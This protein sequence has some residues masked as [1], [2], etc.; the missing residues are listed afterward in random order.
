M[1]LKKSLDY[2]IFRIALLITFLGVVSCAQTNEIKE[3]TSISNWKTYRN[4]D[5]GFELNYPEEYIILVERLG[6]SG[7][8]YDRGVHV[9]SV[10]IPPQLFPNSNLLEGRVAVSQSQ[11]IK[12][13][14][15]CKK[16]QKDETAKE[17][18]ITEADIQINGIAFKRFET[19]GGNVGKFGLRIYRAFQNEICFE[20]DV[21]LVTAGTSSQV[22]LNDVENDVWDK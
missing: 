14:D 19:S 16:L 9:A 15:D 12:S 20:I 13:S 7:G 17:Q 8:T 22:T 4:T 6:N 5:Y 21:A 2:L 10:L 1:E 11:S 18:Q 3:D